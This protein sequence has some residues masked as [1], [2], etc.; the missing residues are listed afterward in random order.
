MD[1]LRFTDIPSRQSVI[2]Q[3]GLQALRRFRFHCFRSTPKT[4]KT[5]TISTTDPFPELPAQNP[6]NPNCPLVT[7]TPAQRARLVSLP[8]C[9]AH[10]SVK[11]QLFGRT[12]RVGHP[13]TA[14]WQ[15]AP[16]AVRA[17]LK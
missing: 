14:G 1:Q 16:Q 8:R 5:S 2:P 12:L 3:L 7:V 4:W 11:L 9:E 17:G 13:R 10:V 15:T 6:Q